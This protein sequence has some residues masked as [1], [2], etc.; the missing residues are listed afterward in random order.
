M[1]SSV[2]AGSIQTDGTSRF[3]P[4]FRWG[5]AVS[6]TPMRVTAPWKFSSRMCDM[7][8]GTDW[9]RSAMASMSASG[10]PPAKVERQ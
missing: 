9:K 5:I 2:A 7:G 10:R 6:V 8:E 1:F 4:G 3:Q